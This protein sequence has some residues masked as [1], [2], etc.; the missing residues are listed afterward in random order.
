MEDAAD[1]RA[2]LVTVNEWLLLSN[3]ERCALW[4][5]YAKEERVAMLA[6]LRATRLQNVPK[7]KYL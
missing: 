7:T 2:R 1:P 6:R 3:S 5:A 4:L